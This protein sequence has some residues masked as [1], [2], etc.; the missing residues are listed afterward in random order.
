MSQIHTPKTG[1]VRIQ[2]CGCG[3]DDEATQGKMMFN[4]STIMGGGPWVFDGAKKKKKSDVLRL[5]KC[6]RIVNDTR[7]MFFF[8]FKRK[9]IYAPTKKSK[10]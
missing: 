1:D 9:E 10:S 2:R 3:L 4:W 7:L 5:V 8:F 6:K